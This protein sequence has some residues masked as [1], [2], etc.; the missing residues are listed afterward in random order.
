VKISRQRYQTGSISKVQR[1]HGFAWVFR[2]RVT[3]SDGKRKLKLQTFSSTEYPTE[4]DVRLAVQG[5][6][7]ALNADTLAGRVNV[8]FS[9]LIDR[10]YVEEFATLR[11]STQTTNKS[12]LELH[13]RPKWGGYRLQDL[14]PLE[15]QH[16][17]NSLPFGAASKARA[18]NMISRLLDLAMLWGYLAVDR[19]PMQL[20]KIKGSTKRRK[21]LVIITPS[22]FRA[23]VSALPEPYSLMVL[24]CGCLG[25]RVSEVLAL[26]WND[27]DLPAKTVAI[28]QVF[29]HSKIQDLPKTDSSGAA[30]PVFDKLATAL[31]DWHSRQAPDAIYVF[32]SPRSG[33]PY[34]D[35]TIL[36][37]HLKPAAAKLG[38][39][40]LG[41][42]TFR[43]SYKTWLATAKVP[44]AIM[45]D[46]MRHSDISTT[47]DV[48]GRTL[49]PELREANTLVAGQLF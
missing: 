35:S 34:S 7:A 10:Y 22:Q 24:V 33:H 38:I 42:H 37:R 8:T 28:H 29:T 3:D 20:I 23:L 32:P 1:A 14:T 15:V 48:Y 21:E 27:F 4:R 13:I 12:I 16:W 49:T 41:W 19:N 45:K 46:M 44:S 26:R 39:N 5:Q 11:H 36:A 17:L 18:R 9:I 30:M 2:Y 43:H 6:L 40:G 25:L 31:H 47:M